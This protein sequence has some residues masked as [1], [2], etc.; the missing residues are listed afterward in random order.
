MTVL[1]SITDRSRWIEFIGLQELPLEVTVKPWK[2]AR[3]D[4]ANDY[5]W[6][7]VYPPLVAVAG[8][9]SDEWHEYF[10]GEFFGWAESTRIDG[11]IEHKPRRTTTRNEAGKRDVMKGKAFNDFLVFVESECAT[12]GAFIERERPV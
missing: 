4:E 1:H 5:L 11:R 7:Y 12:R 9:S 8:F 10:C 6:G 2:P 3:R